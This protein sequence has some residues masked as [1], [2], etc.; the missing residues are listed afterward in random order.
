MLREISKKEKELYD[1]VGFDEKEGV[2]KVVV[3]NKIKKIP[4]EG[5]KN[6]HKHEHKE[7]EHKN[8]KYCAK[9]DVVYCEDCPKEWSERTSWPCGYLNF[10]NGTTPFKVSVESNDKV[11]INHVKCMQG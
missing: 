9:C 6:M 7:C 10:T 1:Q 11:E 4:V 2:L 5:I 3:D 8:L